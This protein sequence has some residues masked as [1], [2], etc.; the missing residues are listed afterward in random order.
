M[1]EKWYHNYRFWIFVQTSIEIQCANF[2]FQ[3]ITMGTPKDVLSLW[4][5]ET[6]IKGTFGPFITGR[7][8]LVKKAILNNSSTCLCL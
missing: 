4:Y 8:K 2:V 5:Y 3:R 7:I 6:E 1:H